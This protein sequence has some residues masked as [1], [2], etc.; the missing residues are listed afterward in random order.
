M[1]LISGK[2]L[3]RAS[4]SLVVRRFLVVL[5]LS[6]LI[7]VIVLRA[8]KYN[9]ISEKT[10]GR[11]AISE[12]KLSYICTSVHFVFSFFF[13]EQMIIENIIIYYLYYIYIII[14]I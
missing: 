2:S 10:K 14:Y 9:I 11:C 6:L 3:L 7:V 12:N 4:I 5:A 1:S 8:Q 13:V